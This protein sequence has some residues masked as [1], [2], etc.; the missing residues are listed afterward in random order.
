[1]SLAQQGDSAGL[2]R[3]VIPGNRR[4]GAPGRLIP[5]LLG[6]LYRISRP[7]GLRVAG[8]LS[9]RLAFRRAAPKNTRSSPLRPDRAMRRILVTILLFLAVLVPAVADVEDVLFQKF[10]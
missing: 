3:R 6:K 1:M 10:E 7:C 5:G 2:S 9:F 4:P 8:R